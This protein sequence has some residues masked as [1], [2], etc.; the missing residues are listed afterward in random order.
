MPDELWIVSLLEAV[1]HHPVVEASRFQKP[2]E[3][4]AATFGPPLAC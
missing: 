3:Q 1:C 2:V 4:A